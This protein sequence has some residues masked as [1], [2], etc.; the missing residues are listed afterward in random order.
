MHANSV[1]NFQWDSQIILTH[2]LQLHKGSFT[3][4]IFATIFLLLWY[5]INWIDLRMY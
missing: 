2:E 4:P 3:Q 1:Q 5:A